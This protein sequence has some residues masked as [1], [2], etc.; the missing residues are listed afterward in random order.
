MIKVLQ[1]NID[2]NIFGMYVYGVDIA[3]V[4]AFNTNF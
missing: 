3:R 4:R 1:N 2:V